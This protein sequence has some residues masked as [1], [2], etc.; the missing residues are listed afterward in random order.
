MK[1]LIIVRHAKAEE[2]T[3]QKPDFERKLANRGLKD[4]DK[5]GKILANQLATPQKWLIS[6]AKRTTETAQIFQ[7]HFDTS[8]SHLQYEKDCYLASAETWKE[9][10]CQT[11]ATIDSLIIFGHNP[12]LNDLVQELVPNFTD[13][14]PTCGIAV[15]SIPS[16]Q[17][18]FTEK[19]NLLLFEFPK[20]HI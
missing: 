4:A 11:D 6:S 13:F 14:M 5:M 7:Q 16:W 8:S 10:I 2:P 19:G 17:N 12:G 9:W 15:I 18:I 20:K 3:F 1:Q